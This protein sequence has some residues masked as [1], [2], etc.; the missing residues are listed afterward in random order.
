M[1]EKIA[2]GIG[3]LG[4][5]CDTHYTFLQDGKLTLVGQKYVAQ[6]THNWGHR[7]AFAGT[8]VLT[9]D[10]ETKQWE[11]HDF[12][13]LVSAENA[14]ET[15]FVRDGKLYLLVFVSFGA[16]GFEKLYRW[17]NNSFIELTILK[18]LLPKKTITEG[19]RVKVITASGIG[20]TSSSNVILVQDDNGDIQLYEI[21]IGKKNA[22]IENT[23]H[24]NSDTN[25]LR[26][27]PV[28]A[29]ISG[30]KMLISYGV[31]GCGFRWESCKLF[32]HDLNTNKT[33]HVGIE[34]DYENLPKFCFSG[35][36]CSYFNEN[37]KSWITASGSVQQ[38]MTG[39]LFYGAVWALKGNVFDENSKPTWV[40]LS[41]TIEQGDHIMDG[42][43][44]YT[45]TK[46]A[47]T[48]VQL[49]EI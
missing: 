44:L 45:I 27:Q 36:Q 3:N 46:D 10:K 25:P 11:R 31:H 41:Q 16:I 33:V 34:G 47:V 28:L 15:L 29:E 4:E 19:H 21:F 32:I 35:P 49:D 38:G 26:G 17:D 43:T 18:E 22:F 9:F 2:D 7:V 39:S 30:D 12:P 40:Q 13:E 42:S 8:Y 20:K 37:T 24:I 5:L 48:K 6:P 1:S 14:D 23:S